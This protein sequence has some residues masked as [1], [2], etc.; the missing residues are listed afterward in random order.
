MRHQGE[1]RPVPRLQKHRHQRDQ[2]HHRIQ[3]LRIQLPD[4]DQKSPRHHAHEVDPE[5]LR[6]QIVPRPLEYQVAE[7]P[8]SRPRDDVQQPEHCGPPP[9][10]GLPQVGK[11]LQVV[12]AEDGVYGE[13]AAEGT[14]VGGHQRDGLEGAEDFEGFFSGRLDD[15]FGVGGVD[16]VDTLAEFG[17]GLDVVVG[18][19]GFL[20]AVVDRG[21]GACGGF[22]GEVAGGGDDGGV[23][24][25]GG[26][27][28][29][30]VGP[31]AG[32]GVFG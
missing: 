29:F 8:A 19:G 23:V 17:V 30:P 31:F 18:G 20:F 12:G 9:G 14:D 13:L 5:L 21:D 3:L 27:G 25:V 6:P 7:E 2:P 26:D 1:I 22:V 15:D 10:R 4:H 28:V 11:V 32:G 16:G 24:L